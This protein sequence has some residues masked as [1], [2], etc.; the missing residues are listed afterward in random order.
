MPSY[1]V[2]LFLLRMASI[3]NFKKAQFHCTRHINYIGENSQVVPP[4]SLEIVLSPTI[5]NCSFRYTS[6]TQHKSCSIICQSLHFL[7]VRFSCDTNVFTVLQK[8]GKNGWW[9][10]VMDKCS[11]SIFSQHITSDLWK[12]R[13]NFLIIT[14]FF[15]VSFCFGTV[16]L[17]I[18]KKK[19]SDIGHNMIMNYFEGSFCMVHQNVYTRLQPRNLC[20][21]LKCWRSID[22]H[23]H[24]YK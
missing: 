7:K 4:S 16:Y 13:N 14:V 18:L 5:S 9:H 12:V 1:Y 6:L 2:I 23:Y 19:I 11:Y 24:D 22:S 8:H 3:Y 15:R 17:E 20:Q 10:V 21:I